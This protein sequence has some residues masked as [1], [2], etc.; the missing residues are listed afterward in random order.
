MSETHIQQAHPFGR[1]SFLKGA[2]ATL[3]MAALT[4]AGC[5]PAPEL[6]DTG[7][8]ASTEQVQ[9]PEEEIY[10]GVCRGNCGGGCRMNVHVREGKVVKTSV[11]EADNPIE[12]CICAKGLSHAQRIYAPERIQYPM[13]RVDGTPRGGDQ[14]ERITWD[15]AISE[16][17]TK[18]KGYIEKFGPQSVGFTHCCGSYGKNYF[19]YYRL[20]NCFGGSM[21]I[22][23]ADSAALHYA[24]YTVKNYSAPYLAG[25]HPQDVMNAK[26]IIF[27]ASN[28]TTSS[29]RRW[30][31]IVEAM[32]KGAKTIVI[33][34]IYTDIAAKADMWVPIRPGTDGALALA[35][36]KVIVDDGKV[37]EEYLIKN[38]NLLFLVK[39]SDGQFLRMSDLGVEPTDTGQLDAMG[40]PVMNDPRVALGADGSYGPVEEV[41]NPTLYGRPEIDGIKVATAYE[42]LLDR[43]NEWPVERASEICDVPADTIYEMARVC[44][45]SPTHFNLGFGNDHWGNGASITACHFVLCALSGNWGIPGGGIGGSQG[46]SASAPMPEMNMFNALYGPNAVFTGMSATLQYLPEVMETGMYGDNPLTVK[47]MF[48]Y[49]ANPLATS[50]DRNALKAA[51][52]KLDLV[53]TVDSVMTDTTRFSDIVLPCPHW[54]EYETINITP[55]EY[56]DFQEKVIDPLY[57]SKSD[58]EIARL[59]GVAM[60]YEDM[61]L[62]DA[63]WHQ[64]FFENDVAKEA[65]VSFD[66]CREKLHW[67]YGPEEYYYGNVDAGFPFVT[68]SGRAEFYIE[69]PVPYCGVYEVDVEAGRLPSFELPLEGWTETV[70]GFEKNPL[71]EKYPMILITHR[72]KLKVHTTFAECPWFAEIHPEPTL[73]INHVDADARGIADGDYVRV[74]NDR[75]EA[76]FRAYIDGSMR[77]GMVWTEH[78]WMQTQ[79]V[80]GHYSELTH[81]KTRHQFPSNH[82]FDT[83]VEI[84][85]YEK[86]GN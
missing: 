35:M 16:I 8:E 22:E 31:Y 39:E 46:Q 52:D 1:R 57:E 72:D 32:K 84:E 55:T 54:F 45:D 73:E 74:F 71:A 86:G 38:T 23:D 3:G 29:L 12:T 49:I 60:G 77:P 18:W 6:S 7:S 19:V 51:F 2:A 42:L 78:T 70:G 69:N 62:S 48:I 76:V 9:A 14:W 64:T 24:D 47:S 15:E 36:M 65:G 44:E 66:Y 58:C 61:D 68:D 83:L 75:G 82:W 5:A 20:R 11:I 80:E 34:P 41:A 37:A 43:I 63:E 10:Q 25:N 4:G 81:T 26:N 67:K 30:N 40:Q 28:S 50:T 79:Y 17:A 27:W 56:C 33:D 59:I 13:R 85:K 21:W 53:V